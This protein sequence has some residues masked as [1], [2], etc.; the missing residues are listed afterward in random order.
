[1]LQV[2]KVLDRTQLAYSD[3]EAS[4]E[5]TTKAAMTYESS[6]E[7]LENLGAKKNAPIKKRD[8]KAGSKSEAFHGKL[9]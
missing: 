9:E 1:M 4:L 8:K 2:G 5:G 6:L 7:E 3:H